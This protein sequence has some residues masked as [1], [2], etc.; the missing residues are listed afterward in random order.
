MSSTNRKLLQTSLVKRL[1]YL[2]FFQNL[3]TVRGVSICAGS[4]ALPGLLGANAKPKFRLGRELAPPADTEKVFP[5]KCFC[6][7]S[8]SKS[9]N[10]L[11]QI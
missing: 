8:Q 9:L 7:H 11:Q 1:G 4:N 2:G 3:P 6:T 5:Q 10:G